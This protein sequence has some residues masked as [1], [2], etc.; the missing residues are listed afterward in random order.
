MIFL[1]IFQLFED[2]SALYQI[3]NYFLHH[4][5]ETRHVKVRNFL[6]IYSH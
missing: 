6:E 1:S 2:I 4:Q 5:N 3:Y